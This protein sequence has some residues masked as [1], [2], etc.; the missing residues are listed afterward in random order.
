MENANAAAQRDLY[1][2][3]WKA[4]MTAWILASVSAACC[5]ER[6]IIECAVV[7][8][9]WWVGILCAASQCAQLPRG[10]R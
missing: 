7:D 6:G 9:R 4:V 10:L 2:S 1:S 3:F 5:D 8:W